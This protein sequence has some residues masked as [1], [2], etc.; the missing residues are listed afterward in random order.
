MGHVVSVLAG[1]CSGCGGPHE[2]DT[3]VPSELWNKVIR[4]GGYADYLCLTCIV[5]AFAHQ[6]QDFTATLW[7][8][9]FRGTAIEVR[10]VNNA[11]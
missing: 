1:R 4:G 6:G 8:G 7:G 11:I 9:N 3:S 2:F 10:V 5:A